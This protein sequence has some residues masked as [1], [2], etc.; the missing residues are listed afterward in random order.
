MN[1]E[2]SPNWFVVESTPIRKLVDDL[3]HIKKGGGD[4]HSTIDINPE[5]KTF[6]ELHTTLR[7]P[8]NK[9]IHY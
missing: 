1:K 9:E 6:G 7:L 5:S 8:G 3:S 2:K 4:I